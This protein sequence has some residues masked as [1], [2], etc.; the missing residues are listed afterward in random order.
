MH[1][2][3]IYIHPSANAKEA[4]VT[5]YGAISGLQSKNP[6]RLLIVTGNFNH[7]NLKTVLPKFHHHV[8]FAM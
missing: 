6:I 8:D 1:I 7:A 5:L 4:L 2:V 3:A